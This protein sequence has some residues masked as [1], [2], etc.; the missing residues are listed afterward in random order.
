MTALI[1]KIVDKYSKYK[2]L[3]MIM[4]ELKSQWISFK[5]NE[6]YQHTV[7]SDYIHYYGLTTLSFNF[8]TFEVQILS[9]SNDR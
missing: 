7:E 2:S 5:T 8:L 9:I 3:W 6:I 4:I 1:I